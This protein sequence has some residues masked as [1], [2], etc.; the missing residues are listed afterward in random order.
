MQVSS[1]PGCMPQLSGK[2]QSWQRCAPT[3]IT[4]RET[5]CTINPNPQKFAYH[6]ASLQHLSVSLAGPAMLALWSLLS[7]TPVLVLLLYCQSSGLSFPCVH[8]LSLSKGRRCLLVILSE[9]AAEYGQEL[10]RIATARDK[11]VGRAQL[12]HH[13]LPLIPELQVS[14][15]APHHP[16]GMRRTVGARGAVPQNHSSAEVLKGLWSQRCSVL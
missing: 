12:Q 15:V 4:L 1:S 13:P 3:W 10:Y 2:K 7:A 9:V 11:G 8:H 6:D 5:L 14:V 16:L